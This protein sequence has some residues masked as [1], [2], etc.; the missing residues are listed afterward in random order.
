MNTTNT[1]HIWKTTLFSAPALGYALTRIPALVCTKNGVLLAFCEGRDDKSDWADINIIYRHSTDGGE[2]WSDARIILDG[3]GGPASNSTPIAG[4][5]GTVHFIC[6]KNYK[7]VYYYRSTDDGLTWSEPRDI[8]SVFDHYKAEYDWEVIAPGPGH[9]IELKNGRLLV[10]VWL[11]DP[12]GPALVGG[13]HRP[14]CVSTIASDDGGLTW[15][16]GDIIANTTDIIRNPSECTV[17]E[18]SDGRVMIN[19]RSESKGYRRLVSISADGT[20]GWTKPVF[21]EALY[22]PICMASFLS[23]TDPETGKKVLLFCNPDSRH[24]LEDKDALHFRSRSNG[25]I[26][27]SRDDGKTWSEWRLIDGGRFGYSDLAS[28]SNGNVYCAYDTAMWGETLHHGWKEIVF[29]RFPLDWISAN[30]FT[31]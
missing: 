13:D 6:Q 31:K 9:A 15:K 29:V 4:K 7:D 3:E 12:A 24:D 20:T 19:I 25:V 23:A 14:S 5:D 1:N 17:A 26:K 27:L 2:T 28:D 30:P 22:D 21:D 10:P 18:L 11:C 8:T 16:R